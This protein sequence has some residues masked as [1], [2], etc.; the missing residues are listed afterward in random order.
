MFLLVVGCATSPDCP[1]TVAPAAAESPEVA[2]APTG[3]AQVDAEPNTE[4]NVA[5]VILLVR[6]AEKAADGTSD[7]PL[8]DRG[9]RR[10]ECL[11]GLLA[12]FEPTHLLATQYQRTQATL[13]P[14]AAASSLEIAVIEA[15]DTAAWEQTLAELPTG[16][17]AVVAGHSNTLPGMVAALGGRLDGLNML[18][19]IP[20]DDYDRMVHIV[21]AG[22][23]PGA[24]YTTAYCTE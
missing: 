5:P 6:H 15:K 7:P 24:I 17:R 11:A 12:R 20:S 3:P 10:A 4:P 16:A 22:S 8:T 9:L 1:P 21:R 18:G 14:L 13:R 19:N 2:E 23:G